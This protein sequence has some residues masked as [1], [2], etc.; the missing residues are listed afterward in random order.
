MEN[1]PFIFPFMSGL[2]GV[3]R[4]RLEAVDRHMNEGMTGKMMFGIIVVGTRQFPK[5][6]G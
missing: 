4:A 1:I 5:M 3:E 6:L 2:L